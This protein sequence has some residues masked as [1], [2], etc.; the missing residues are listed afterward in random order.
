MR[1]PYKTLIEK[2]IE[3]LKKRY[4]DRFISLII[5][6]SVARGEMKKDSDIDLLLIIDSITKRR[7]K[8]QEE[9][10]EV[11][12]ELE[13]HLNVLFDEGYFTDFSP[14]I[15]TPEEAVRISPLYLD[16]VE[17]AIIVHDKDNFFKNILENVRKR[18]KE[19]GSKRISMGKRWY[20]ILKPDYHFGEA[21]R[22]E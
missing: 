15:K 14:I 13:E 11:E 7:L 6:G 20:W 4:G 21:I 18:L 3:A 19:L 1:E 8:R 2:L 16:M 10:M 12:K 22:I 9:F 17:D 5:F